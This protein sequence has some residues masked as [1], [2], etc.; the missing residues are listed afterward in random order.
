VEVSCTD[1]RTLWKLIEAIMTC[2][3]PVEQPEGNA[4]QASAESSPLADAVRS[5]LAET[6]HGWL[7]RVV[8]AIEGGS[9]V[10]RGKVPS[11]YLKQMAQTTVMAVPGVEVMRNEL[12]VEGGNR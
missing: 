10:L 2:V 8:V 9:V 5:A 4:P 12:Q 3:A 11:F 1:R 7:Q 6:G